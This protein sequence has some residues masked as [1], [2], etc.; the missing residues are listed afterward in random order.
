MRVLTPRPL[1]IIGLMSG[2]SAD[3]TDAALVEFSEGEERPSIALLAFLC[4]PFPEGLRQAVLD[5]AALRDCRPASLIAVSEALALEYAAAVRDVARLARI[6]LDTVD[7]LACHGQTIWHQPVPWAAGAVTGRGTLQ[8]GSAAVLAAETGVPVVSDFR[9]ADMAAGGQGAPLVPFADLALFGDARETRAVQN[10]GGIANVTYLPAGGGPEQ[11]VAFDTGPG[12]MVVDEVVRTLTDGLLQ[13]DAEGAMALAGTPCPEIVEA[14]L[15]EEPFF[16]QPPPKS[17]GRELFGRAFVHE[18]FLPRCRSRGLGKYDTVATATLLT[19][20]SIALAYRTWLPG[21]GF[22]QRVILG[23]GGV[24]NRALWAML[25]DLL[26]PAAVCTHADFG[27][28]DDA[29]EAMAFALLAYET[30]HGRP[31]NI[32]SATGARRPT[33]LGSITPTPDARWPRMPGLR[34]RR[35]G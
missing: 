30:L 27:I 2:T 1:R 12:N 23:G 18:R 17:T 4:R 32:P 15:H 22:P 8:I 34:K 26:K 20:Q 3:G 16:G 14:I 24:H 33:V 35:R 6:S 19:A 9:S 21:D 31:S 5:L 7:A 28:P 13:Y 10:I 29:K 25:E 11:V